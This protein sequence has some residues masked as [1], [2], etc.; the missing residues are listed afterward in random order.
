MPNVFSQFCKA[1]LLPTTIKRSLKVALLV[2][3]LL[4]FIN[5]F[6]DISHREWPTLWV[7]MMTYLVPYSVSSYAIAASILDATKHKNI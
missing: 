3:T 4:V 2:G 7:V 6:D 1:V 5:Q